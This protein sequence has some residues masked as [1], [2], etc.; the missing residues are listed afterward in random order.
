MKT[1]MLN[2]IHPL[3]WAIVSTMLLSGC[4]NSG[5]SKGSNSGEGASNEIRI[6]ID[7]DQTGDQIPEEFIGLSFET[8]SVRKNNAGTN[9]YFFSAGNAQSLHIFKQLGIKHLRIGGG[10][11]DMNQ[12]AP[13]FQDIDELF[14]FV[15]KLGIKVIYSFR[16]L[17]GKIDNEVQV[18]KY[19][20]DNY[21]EHIECF[22]IG[23]E[24]DW[25]SYH[26]EDPEI[27]DYPTYLA[28]WKRFAEAI[29]REIPEARFTGPN[30]GSNFPVTGAKDT[31]YNGVSWTVNFAK[32]LKD[33][34]WLYQLAQH[35]YVG[36]D[37]TGRDPQEMIDKILSRSWNNIEYPALYNATLA[38]VLK[39]GFTYRLG[40]SNSF[41]G[42]S[43]GGSNSF[44][45]ALF[46]LDYMHWWAEHQCAGVNFH[47]KQWVL[48][49]PIGKD[50]ARNFFV[51]PV[52]YGIMAFK[53]GSRG[54]VQPLTMENAGQL[55]VT[56]YAV[57]DKNDVYVTLINKEYGFDA[58]DAVVTI[59]ID[60][61]VQRIETIELASPEGKASSR[62]ATLGNGVIDNTAE[63][64]GTWNTH[65]TG[66]TEFDL[67]HTSA[68]IIHLTLK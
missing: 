52:G 42:Q 8:G 53:L 46:S 54:A 39:E 43:D 17:N 31:N 34:G 60:K 9:G 36:Q 3:L 13:T 44:A 21:K 30:T 59:D 28:K 33:S 64:N 35:N 4:G 50:D 20:W 62:M 47:N 55:N 49:A 41:S 58:Q 27:R 10:S 25:D 5:K 18:A 26:R 63:W 22:A 7:T 40:E 16:L 29:T 2:G 57:R 1:S 66:K 19:I 56:A 51:N 45:T 68:M 6:T 11:V 32:D 23:N 37:A 14:S 12:V 15:D 24:P 65:D 38:P 67:S 48:N 61:S